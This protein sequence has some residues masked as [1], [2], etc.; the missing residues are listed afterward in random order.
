VCKA[1]GLTPN[2][3]NYF[4]INLQS[5][6]NQ[7]KYNFDE[8][9][10]QAIRPSRVKVLARRR[11]NVVYNTIPKS[12]EWLIVNYAINVAEGV[13]LGFY[14]FEGEKLRDD[15]IRLCKPSTCTSMQKKKN[16]DDYFLV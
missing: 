12:Q 9:R 6:Y 4:Y 5:L 7:H 13:I 10:I 1:Q 3:C 14:I 15:Y 8:T 11:S 16:M 2:S